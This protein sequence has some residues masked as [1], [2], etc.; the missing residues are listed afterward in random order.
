MRLTTAGL[1]WW[2]SP[3]YNHPTNFTRNTYRSPLEQRQAPNAYM[4]VLG[5]TEY[6]SVS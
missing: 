6:A 3:R 4:S 5:T 1:T 2:V